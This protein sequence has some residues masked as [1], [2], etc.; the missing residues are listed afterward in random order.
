ME[1]IKIMILALGFLITV[2]MSCMIFFLKLLWIIYTRLPYKCRVK[3]I[4]QCCVLEQD[5]L[6]E[7]TV[8]LSIWKYKLVIQ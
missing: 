1:T 5:N 6:L 8:L 4:F 2:L 7:I 3:L